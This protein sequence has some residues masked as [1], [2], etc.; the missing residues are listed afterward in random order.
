LLMIVVLICGQGWGGAN[1]SL[2]SGTGGTLH[3]PVL[4]RQV[5]SQGVLKE[6]K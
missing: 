5:S 1:E 3:H 2:D 6:D 4:P